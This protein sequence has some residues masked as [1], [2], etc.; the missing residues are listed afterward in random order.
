MASHLAGKIIAKDPV[1]LIDVN[2]AFSD[3]I[4]EGVK[5]MPCHML[6]FKV[7]PSYGFAKVG[8]KMSGPRIT[9]RSHQK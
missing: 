3:S 8:P 4:K 9:T 7:V 5:V 6:Y 1:A 2:C